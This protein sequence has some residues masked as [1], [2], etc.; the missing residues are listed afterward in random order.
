MPATE[1][2]DPLD[3]ALCI[4]SA[5]ESRGI[6]YAI[7]GALAYGL[8]AVPR[9]T[10]DV[11][12][13]IFVGEPGLSNVIDLL[14]TLGVRIDAEEARRQ[15][16]REGMLVGRWG[17]YRIDVFTPSIDFSWEAER[18]RVR[19]EIAGRFAWFLSAEAISVFKLLFFRAKDIGDIERLVALRPELDRTYIREQIVAMMGEGDERVAEWDRI[20]SE[21][22]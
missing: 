5:L 10:I 19:H 21:H 17:L 16:E 15:N 2:D 20:V 12:V 8:W 11:D 13:N 14:R 18:T 1:P 4:A 7:G 3:A 9:A 22:P 6:G